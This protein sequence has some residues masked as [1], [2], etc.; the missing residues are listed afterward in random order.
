[1]ERNH[2]LIDACTKDVIIVDKKACTRYIIITILKHGL[3][4]SLKLIQQAMGLNQI[5][6]K[7]PTTAICRKNTPL[8]F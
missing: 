3:L 4:L 2:H 7:S 5:P 6:S 8:S 1:M